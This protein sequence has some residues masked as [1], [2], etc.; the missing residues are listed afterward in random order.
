MDLTTFAPM[1]KIYYDDGRP[2]LRTYEDFP[3]LRLLRRDEGW[4]GDTHDIPIWHEAGQAV[5]ADFATALAGKTAAGEGKYTKWVL[6][7]AKK[8]GFTMLDRLTMLRSQSDKY[9]FLSHYTAGVDGTFSTLQR[10]IA[11]NI[12]RTRRS[13]RGTVASVGNGSGTNDKVTLTDRRDILSFSVGMRL[14]FTDTS[15]SNA[16]IVEDS[17]TN[18]T[19]SKIDASAGTFEVTAGPGGAAMNLSAAGALDVDLVATD[20]IY[21]KGDVLTATDTL[22]LA[23]FEDWIPATAPGS[24]TF[25]GV[26]RSVNTDKL[27]GL[28]V[29][30][31]AL[32]MED[33]L[34]EGS[35][36]AF[37][38]G[39][40]LTH[41]IVNPT[42]FGQLQREMGTK[43]VRDPQ[44]KQ[45]IGTAMFDVVTNAGDQKLYADPHCQKGIM[46]G[47]D[48]RTW[49]LV[50]TRSLPH[51]F[52]DD[53]KMLREASA[54]AYEVRS[55]GYGQ[56]ACHYPGGNVR[57]SLV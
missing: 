20:K 35:Q 54:D 47:L 7:P 1:L 37:E 56:L 9:A 21:R 2:P 18:A 19:V 25:F 30:G 50:S 10:D 29:A 8:Y 28:R 3:T 11:H 43:L 34:I 17:A 52:D 31:S 51:L 40:K 41:W 44:G 4:K 32:S 53:F 13:Q 55:G 15:N 6:T 46:W 12:F 5:A 49:K 14:T 48:I 57:V 33:S 26:D 24:T 27:G 39:A 45:L 22:N 38:A 23:G 42:D 36:R 16:L